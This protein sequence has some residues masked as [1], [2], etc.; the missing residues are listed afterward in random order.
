MELCCCN[1]GWQLQLGAEL[2]GV[3]TPCR[4][5]SGI[6]GTLHADTVVRMQPTA[7]LLLLGPTCPGWLSSNWKTRQDKLQ[8][9]DGRPSKQQQ[10]HAF[11]QCS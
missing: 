4:C 7:L 2:E 5:A 9:V 1:V 10:P 8:L 3:L 11:T 6:A